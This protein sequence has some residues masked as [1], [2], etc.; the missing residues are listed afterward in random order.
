MDARRHADGIVE[1]RLRA[2]EV[3][4][5]SVWLDYIRGSL[6]TSTSGSCVA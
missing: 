6:I 1:N 2:I 4:G 5:Q 3:F